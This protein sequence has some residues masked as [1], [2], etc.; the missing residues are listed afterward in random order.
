M[1]DDELERL[2]AKELHDLAVHHALHHLDVK[3]FWHLLEVVPA[4]E[5]AAGDVDEAMS[6]VQT[7]RTRVDD[8]TDAGQ[9][10][11]AE[12]LRPFY[13]EYLRDHGVAPSA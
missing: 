12:Q 9:G 6:D 13:L 1:A 4:A 7:L 5:A 11:V 2:S 10:D 3:F 8:L